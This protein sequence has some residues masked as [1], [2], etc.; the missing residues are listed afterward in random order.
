MVYFWVLV[1][2]YAAVYYLS[3]KA[4]DC[5]DATVVTL[6]GIFLGVVS[7][8]PRTLLFGWLCMAGLL[9]VLDR[10]RRTGKG[11]W[12]LPLLLRFGSISI[13]PGHLEWSCYA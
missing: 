3:C 7:I 11:L 8:G 10:F 5:K 2:I 12:T 4:A 1:L 13:L 6:I 9:V